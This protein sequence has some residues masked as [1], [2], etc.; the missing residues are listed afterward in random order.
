MMRS[1]PRISRLG[2]VLIAGIG[3]RLMG[4]DGFGPVVVARLSNVHL[5]D[6]IDLRDFGT[7]GVT[8][9]TELG[10]YDTVI[11]ID[12]MEMDGAP[13][14]L[15]CLEIDVEDIDADASDL[16]RFTLH[17]SGVEGLLRF[18]KAIGT[19]PARIIL[20]GCKPK[21]IGPS[22]IL[23]EEVERAVHEAVLLILEMLRI[24]G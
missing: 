18:S 11:F 10:D 24:E 1:K 19:L 12:T 8:I 15:K 17:E 23:S 2:K 13:G 7:A 14:T 20:V 9:A 3:N 22:L 16:W 4:D 21:Y 5:P 6:N